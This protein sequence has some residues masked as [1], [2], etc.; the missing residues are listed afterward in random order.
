MRITKGKTA[1]LSKQQM[2]GFTLMS[3]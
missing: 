3:V 1:S 2:S